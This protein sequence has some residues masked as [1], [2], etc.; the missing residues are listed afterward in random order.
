M[1]I[2]IMSLQI[3]KSYVDLK[4]V[5]VFFG[6]TFLSNHL[7]FLCCIYLSTRHFT[8]Q[9]YSFFTSSPLVSLALWSNTTRS[10]KNN[11]H[12]VYI[13]VYFL[14]P[15]FSLFLWCINVRYFHL[16]EMLVLDPQ[17][18]FIIPVAVITFCD[19]SV[20]ILNSFV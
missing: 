3:P 11:N 20:T 10:P 19:V 8:R 2:I 7:I 6:G 15:I 18:P 16:K 12:Q 4:N 13:L 14:F 17:L 1:L 5:G 9:V